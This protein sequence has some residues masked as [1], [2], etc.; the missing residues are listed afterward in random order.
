MAMEGGCRCGA[1]RFRIEAEPIA[2]RACWCRDCQY[3]GSGSATI[4]VI[5]PSQDMH[6]TGRTADYVS[7]ADSGAVMH[8]RFCPACGTPLFSEAEARP[9]LIIVR[10]GAL[11]DPRAV[12]PQAAIWTASAPDWAHI[13]PDLPAHE[14]QPPAGAGAPSAP[15]T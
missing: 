3:W 5:F 7:A 8:R 6:L 10:A 15:Q 9:H 12:R 2:A 4:N 11:D 1:V 13:D 14:G